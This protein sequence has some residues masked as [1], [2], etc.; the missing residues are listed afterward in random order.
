MGKGW[1]ALEAR[2]KTRPRREVVLQ[3][4]A[5]PTGDS[6]ANRTGFLPAWGGTGCEESG[7]NHLE[8]SEDGRDYA[9]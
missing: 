3:K 8:R 4:E 1:V 9:F 5:V 6:M 2:K 7:S